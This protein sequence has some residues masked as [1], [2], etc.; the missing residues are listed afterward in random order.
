MGVKGTEV[1]SVFSIS[2]GL[3]DRGPVTHIK[4]QISEQNAPFR[5]LTVSS[6]AEG[7]PLA[8]HTWPWACCS[9]LPPHMGT[10]LSQV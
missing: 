6:D 1:V 9:L 3:G 8:L 10:E 7:A 5:L 4:S 2:Y